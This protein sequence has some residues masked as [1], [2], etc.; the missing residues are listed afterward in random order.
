VTEKRKERAGQKKEGRT[1]RASGFFV[2]STGIWGWWKEP[3][4]SLLGK[5]IKQQQQQQQQQGSQWLVSS[6]LP[7]AF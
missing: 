6:F 7:A 4:F 5:N 1:E 3:A 2:E